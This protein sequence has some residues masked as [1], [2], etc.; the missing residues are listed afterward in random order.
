MLKNHLISV[1]RLLKQDILNII[2]KAKANILSDNR[3]N[4]Y[5]FRKSESLKHKN[6][7]NLFFEPSTRTRSAFE[8][9]AK[10]LSANVINLD[11]EKSSLNK[12]ESL[13]DTILTIK[14]M[15]PDAIVMRHKE[16]GIAASIAN[17]CGEEVSFINGGDG[18]HAHPTQGLL[19]I[20]TIVKHKPDPEN[21]KIAIIGDIVHS[22]VANSQIAAL[23]ILNYKNIHLIAPAT[24]LPENMNKYG[25][26]I[27]IHHDLKTGIKDA[28]VVSCLRIQKERIQHTL[29]LDDNDFYAR[30]G[31]TSEI[32]KLAKPDAIVMHP[33]PVNRGVEISSE[34]ADG[35]QSVILEQVANGV[36][37]RMAIF[38]LLLLA[39]S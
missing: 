9:A 25:D 28:D 22:R 6:I 21:T 30:Y 8:F 27:T 26:N 24:L 5:S 3:K 10:N 23:E 34:V 4:K 16:S 29:I 13:R 7:I 35:P 33:G 17:L 37:I 32:M 15:Q 1:D 11:L 14:A 12:N 19:D 31:I 2:D 20:F 38:E 18:T 39:S 36:A